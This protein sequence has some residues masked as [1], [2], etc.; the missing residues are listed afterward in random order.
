MNNLNK[1][2]TTTVIGTYFFIL[3]YIL[4]LSFQLYI[5]NT[6][7]SEVKDLWEKA[8]EKLT[9]LG[10]FKNKYYPDKINGSDY[11]IEKLLYMDDKS[12]SFISKKSEEI[13]KIEILLEFNDI[14]FSTL[15]EEVFLEISFWYNKPVNQ[16]I[17]I[18]YNNFAILVDDYNFN[19]SNFFIDK[20]IYIDKNITLDNSKIYVKILSVGNEKF[21]FYLDKINL[22]IL[23]SK[24][25][26]IIYMINESSSTINIVSIKLFNNNE[27]EEIILKQEITP[28][29]IMKIYIK[30]QVN[31]EWI[32]INTERGN[33]LY[34][35]IN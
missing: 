16:K 27:I 34:S 32:E 24:N 23:S 5:Q 8:N 11:P 28:L 7:I 4:L 1:K 3:I 26:F 25:D 17:F 10:S 31:A 33:K 2:G 6:G 15:A 9:I 22:N 20:I 13:Y 21:T 14:S 19:F 29:K 18:V 12:I 35:K 30:S